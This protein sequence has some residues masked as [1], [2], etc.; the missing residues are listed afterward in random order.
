MLALPALYRGSPESIIGSDSRV[1]VDPTTTFPH[2][3]VVLITFNA[4]RCTGWLIDADTV[5]TAGH[6]VH[7]GNGGP[8]YPL[9]SYEI[10]PGYNGSGAGPF[11][12]CRAVRL[13]SVAGWTRDGND[14]FDYGAIKL[15]CDIGN[16][17]G[18]LAYF[19][20]TDSLLNFTT[21]ISGYP[22]DKPLTQWVSMD[23][24]RATDAQR[25]FYKNDTLGGQSGSPVWVSWRFC[26]MCVLAIHAY[27]SNGAN[28]HGTRIVKAVFDNLNAWKNS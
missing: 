19:W 8:F 24:V 27:G 2:R 13:H 17:V 5:A 25:V 10:Y 16:R 1:R 4:G 21:R 9:A 7:P 11:G 14:G 3:A 22:G 18:W 26:K 20:T 28:N 23:F 15:N 12:S 6:C